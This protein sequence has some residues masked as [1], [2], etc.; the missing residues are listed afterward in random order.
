MRLKLIVKRKY[1]DD[2]RDGLTEVDPLLIKFCDP[3]GGN[4]IVE[5][6]GNTAHVQFTSDPSITATGFQLYWEASKFSTEQKDSN[7]LV[8]VTILFQVHFCI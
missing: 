8:L 6:N 7:H 2:F 1:S 5:T 3:W 4:S